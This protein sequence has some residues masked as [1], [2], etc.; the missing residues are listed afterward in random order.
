VNILLVTDDMALGG[1]QTH[2]CYLSQF[3]VSQNH[4][5]ILTAKKGELNDKLPAEVIFYNLDIKGKNPFKV[6]KNLYKIKIIINDHNI[7]VI[8]LHFL[9]ILPFIWLI[10]LT[11]KIRII[12]TIHKIL[13]DTSWGKKSILLKFGITL[14][15]KL[16]DSIIL[17]NKDGILEFGKNCDKCRIIPNGIL[18]QNHNVKSSLEKTNNQINF[19]FSGRLIAHKNISHLINIINFINKDKTCPTSHLHIFGTG[20]EIKNL[21]DYTKSLNIENEVTFYGYVNNVIDRLYRMDAFLITSKSEGISYSLLE[22]LSVGKPIFGYDVPGV[23]EMVK[24]DYNGKLFR[25]EAWP[26]LAQYLFEQINQDVSIFNYFGNN[27]IE[28]V[29]NKYSMNNLGQKVIE[30]YM[31]KCVDKP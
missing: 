5:V 30:E 17:L 29:K 31:S 9:F 26:E 13:K 11:T 2:L 3:L 1:T 15:R 19:A 21:K 28:V 27:S 8:H 20:P 6:L 18:F 24:D 7:D 23:N 10:T 25:Y 12:T 14:T 16:S 22:V 4:N